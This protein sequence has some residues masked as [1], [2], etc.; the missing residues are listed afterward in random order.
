MKTGKQKRVVRNTLHDHPLMRKGGV[1][2]KSTKALR[3]K[4]KQKLKNF[5][6]Y[7]KINS[8][9]FLS[10]AIDKNRKALSV[11][12]GNWLTSLA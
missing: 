10:N 2:E 11:S 4:E 1:H 7:L 8:T 6:R 12:E 3:Q 9:L 5:W